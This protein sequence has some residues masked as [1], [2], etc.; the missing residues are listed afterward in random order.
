MSAAALIAAHLNAPHGPALTPEEVAES[1]R[2]GA[3]CGASPLARALA[4]GMFCEIDTA[5]LVRAA[6]ESGASV[7]QLDALYR[8]TL[9]AGMVRVPEWERIARELAFPPRILLPWAIIP[10]RE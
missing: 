9:A 6:R 1:M 10:A 5:L 2:C 3:P 8:A 7:A 4:A